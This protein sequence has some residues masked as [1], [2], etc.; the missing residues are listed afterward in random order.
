[1]IAL[2]KQAQK[3]IHASNYFHMEPQIKLAKALCQNSFA[4]RVFFCNS[5]AEANEA[6]IKLARKYAKENLSGQKYEIIT[7][8]KSF[9][10]RT[11]A[12]ITATGQEKFQKA[13]T[14]L[15]PGFTYVPFGDV[16]AV[17][18]AITDK[19]CAV[20]MEPIQAEGGSTS[21]RMNTSR[22]SGRSLAK[23][24]SCLSWTRYR[25]G[26]AAPGSCSP[27]NISAS[28]RTS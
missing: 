21:R 24:V 18:D 13:F 23:R 4:D 28:S 27:M 1:M 2:Q 11:M 14:P 17:E 6:A 15:L 7:A 12:T 10:G 8:L 20:M 3:L 19:T 9:H 22:N 25:P 16:K 26:W 5:G